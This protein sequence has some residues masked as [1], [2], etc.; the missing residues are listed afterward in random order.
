MGAAVETLPVNRSDFSAF[1]AALRGRR[2]LHLGHKDADC[3]ALGSAYAMSCVLP[4]DVGCAQ[5][6]KVSAWDLAAW[7]GLSPLIDPDP[8]KYDYVMIYDT[9]S[10]DLLGYD[11]PP[12]YALFDHHVEGGHRFSN[13]DSQL[14]AGAEWCWVRPVESTCSVVHDLIVVHGLPVTREMGVALAAGILTDTYWL[15]LADGA[16]L[17][18][19]AAVLEGAGLYVEEVM[20]AVDSPGRRLDRRQAVLAALRGAQETVVGNWSVLAAETDSHD[21]GFSV[22]GA[23]GRLGGDVRVVS[24]PKGDL[25]MVMIECDRDVVTRSGIDLSSVAAEI[26]RHF[27][28]DD[29]WGTRMWGRVIAPVSRDKLLARAVAAVAGVLQDTVQGPHRSGEA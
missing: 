9:L 27:G 19:L 24:F 1:L 13:F 20:A 12:R 16:V 4:G 23:L 26:G 15:R 14:A 3:D 6:L 2:L 8:T 28:S 22:S 11:L 29:S 7:L 10:R 21:H 18:R 25:A 17:R 5:G